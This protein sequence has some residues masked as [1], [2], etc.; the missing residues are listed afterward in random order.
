MV[1]TL[2]E[3]I[4]ASTIIFLFIFSSLIPIVIGNKINDK[5]DDVYFDRFYFANYDLYENVK[6]ENYREN[7]NGEVIENSESH[8]IPISKKTLQILPL[9]G[10]MDSAWPMKCHDLH[11]TS[12]SPYSTVGSPD[13]EEKWRFQS[14]GWPEGSPVIDDDGV[15]YFGATGWYIYAVYPNGTLKWHHHTG[16]M[17]LSAPAIDEDG[18]V[19]VGSFDAKLYAINPDGSRKWRIGLSGSITS[20]PAIDE[21]GTV[22]V[23]TMWGG[24]NGG[25]IH[26]VNPNGTEKWRYKTDYHICSDPAIGDDGTIYIGSSDDYLYAMNPNGTLKWRFETGDWVKSHP[27][28]TDDGTIYVGSFDGYTYAINP[29]GTEKW[30]FGNPG[31]GANSAAIASD[32]T[33]IICGDA[34]YAVNPDGTSKWT[35]D[36]GEDNYIGHPSACISSDGT[37]Y[38]GSTHDST[39]G[40]EIIVVNQDGTLKWR[41]YVANEW[42][43][44][45]PCIGEDGTVYIGSSSSTFY[46]YSYGYLH[47][48]GPGEPNEPPTAPTIDGPMEVIRD[49]NYDY[50]FNSTDPEGGNIRYWIDWDDGLILEWEGP[51]TSGVEITI[52][53]KWEITGTYTIKSRTEDDKGLYSDWTYLEVTVPMNQLVQNQGFPLLQQLLERFP[54]AFP[55]LRQLLEL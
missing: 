40:G 47:A 24:G 18:T 25:V 42:M 28:I 10:P 26:A 34:I 52:R 8:K 50:K 20:S 55:I 2:I 41:K 6:Y 43:G 44:S 21:D 36:I 53:N 30:R 11:H 38:V 1:K 31:S 35:F 19:Y 3:K 5:I 4:L 32:G 49:E 51:H 45:S 7:K 13:L 22:Y 12:Q 39:Q 23:G 54:N 15:L 17:M 37:I 16:G 33:I 29:D 46:G 48:F 27:S 9:D 14:D